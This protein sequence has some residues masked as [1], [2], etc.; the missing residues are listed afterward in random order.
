[1][2]GLGS[3]WKKLTRVALVEGEGAGRGGG[4]GRRVARVL[5]VGAVHRDRPAAGGGH[6][7][8]ADAETNRERS[9][10]YKFLGLLLR[11][12]SCYVSKDGS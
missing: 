6:E 4:V 1:M 12:E 9:L 7:D 5:E 10:L 8:A 2:R 3:R 11:E